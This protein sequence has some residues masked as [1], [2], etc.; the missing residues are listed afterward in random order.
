[1]YTYNLSPISVNYFLFNVETYV[2]SSIK[3]F[4]VS[5][6]KEKFYKFIKNNLNIFETRLFK[7][8]QN[9]YKNNCAYV[10]LIW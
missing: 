10:S 6:K 2:E 4:N 8:Y 7:F 3:L 1:M 9:V 5:Y